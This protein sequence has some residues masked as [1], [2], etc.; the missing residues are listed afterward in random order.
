MKDGGA[1]EDR[2]DVLFGRM[3]ALETLRRRAEQPGLTALV[4]RPQAGKS[5]LVEELG[6]TLTDDHHCIVGYH[7][8]SGASDNVLR[9]VQDLYGRWLSNSTFREQARAAYRQQSGGALSGTAKVLADVFGD[10]PG[11]AKPIGTLAKSA[12]DGLLHAR[13]DLQTGRLVLTPIQYEQAK[14]LLTLVH[15]VSKKPLILFLDAWEQTVESA[16]RDERVLLHGFVRDLDS[17]PSCHVFVVLR[18]ESPA[19]QH[20]QAMHREFGSHAEVVELGDLELSEPDER[21]RLATYLHKQVPV[22]AKVDDGELISL[23]D[24]Y[25]GVVGRW[26]KAHTK[27]TTAEALR[28]L[29]KDSHAN[30]YPELVP[31][32]DALADEV[33]DVAMRIALMD[34]AGINNWDALETVIMNGRPLSD[35]DLLRRDGVLEA[36][37]PPTYGHTKRAEV[38]REVLAE[39]YSHGLQGSFA[40]LIGACAAQVVDVDEY[41]RPFVEVVRDLGNWADASG[42]CKPGTNERRLIHVAMSLFRESIPTDALVGSAT[43]PLGGALLAIGLFNTLNHAEAEDDLPR[44]DA[45]LDELRALADAHDEPAVRE[46][47]AKAES[48]VD[49]E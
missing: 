15:E 6:R 17:W 16:L 38:A 2:R 47:L 36:S 37:D 33:R 5:W 30:R 12:I 8:S 14:D 29:A 20:V 31:L 41:S 27:P 44:R 39:R 9:A 11:I 48:F 42:L 34:N 22:T 19:L 24:G 43:A 4:G 26:L 45:L 3:R 13:E 1:F 7:Q 35:L 32:I 18:P 21:Q 46:S 23:I 40:Q 25:A 28:Q 10:A 49:D